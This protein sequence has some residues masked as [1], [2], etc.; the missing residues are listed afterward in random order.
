M[1]FLEAANLVYAKAVYGMRPKSW[2]LIGDVYVLKDGMWL[3]E[4]HEYHNLHTFRWP[5][6]EI[7]FSEWVVVSQAQVEQERREAKKL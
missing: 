2:P 5:Q 1:T 7:L 4:F 3:L 6:P